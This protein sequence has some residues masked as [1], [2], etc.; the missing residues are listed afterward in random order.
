MDSQTAT[1]WLTIAITGVGFW[2]M[3]R[4]G[5]GRPPSEPRIPSRI[6]SAVAPVFLA[7]MS[8]QFMASRIGSGAL[9]TKIAL[10][11]SA[12]LAAALAFVPGA[13]HLVSVAALGVFVIENHPILGDALYAWLVFVIG[14]SLLVSH[15]RSR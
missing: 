1:A 2:V 10:V 3:F 7:A 11:G 6:D 8:L 13:K 9:S 15:F 4:G 12:F 14:V 5:R